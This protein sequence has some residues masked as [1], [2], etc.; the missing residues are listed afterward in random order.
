MMIAP[1]LP[2]PEAARRSDPDTSHAAAERAARTGAELELVIADTVAESRFPLTAE[3]IAVRVIEKHPGRWRWSS[4]VTAVSRA[5]RDHHIEYSTADGVTAA[6]CKAR[7]Y[8][9]ATGGGHA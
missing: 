1:E 5:R 8:V 6:G 2:F 7:T 3:Q 9:I 4:V